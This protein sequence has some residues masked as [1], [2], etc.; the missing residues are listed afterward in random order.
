MKK[1]LCFIS[2]Y[3]ILFCI[4][5]GIFYI[6]GFYSFTTL[7]TKLVLS[8]IIAFPLVYEIA[9]ILLYTLIRELIKIRKK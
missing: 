2:L 7:P 4:N 1:I 6:Y 9:I 5:L 3:I 8:R